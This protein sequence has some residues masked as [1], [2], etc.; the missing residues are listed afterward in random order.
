MTPSIVSNVRMT[1]PRNAFRAMRSGSRRRMLV[2][3]RITGRD[4][5]G[6]RG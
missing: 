2:S 5:A 3:R 6:G 4:H 1:L